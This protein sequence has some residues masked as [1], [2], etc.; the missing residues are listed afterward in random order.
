MVY[1]WAS[2]VDIVG[3]VK[4]CEGDHP[5]SWRV[6]RALKTTTGAQSPI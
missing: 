1:Q 4:G 5:E 6:L 2:I 3:I